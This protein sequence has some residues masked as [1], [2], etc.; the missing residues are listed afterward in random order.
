VER[1]VFNRTRSTSWG[2]TQRCTS[3]CK[4]LAE[5][6][7]TWSEERCGPVFHAQH[8]LHCLDDPSTSTATA[9]LPSP[10]SARSSPTPLISSFSPE[11]FAS[12]GN[13]MP[14]GIV[15]VAISG[16][17]GRCMSVTNR[18]P[19]IRRGD[20]RIPQHSDNSDEVTTRAVTTDTDL[21]MPCH[22]AY[23]GC[24]A[25]E[26]GER[27]NTLG[28]TGNQL[29]SSEGNIYTAIATVTFR[30]ALSRDNWSFQWRPHCFICC[31]DTLA[32]CGGTGCEAATATNT[33]IRRLQRPR[34][35][36]Q[37]LQQ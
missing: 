28:S 34:G 25:H 13:A 31:L 9:S 29:R 10:T 14:C 15:D 12:V 21:D 23:I 2:W 32:V 20:A 24:W 35:V 26:Q 18:P 37:H 27:W 30:G 11:A 36:Q 5:S 6:R 3:L 8:R 33:V 17:S 4:A 1:D 16:A 19:T 22:E 7:C